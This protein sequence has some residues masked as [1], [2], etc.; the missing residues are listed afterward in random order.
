MEQNINPTTESVPVSEFKGRT[1]QLIGWRLLGTLIS[2]VTLGICMPWAHCMVMRWETNHTYIDGQQLYFDGKG[3]QLFGRYLLWGLLTIVTIGIYGLFVPV[4]FRR[5]RA[6]HTRLATEAEKQPETPAAAPNAAPAPEAPSGSS[7]GGIIAGFIVAGVLV[8][9]LCG[10][11]VL[12]I[13]TANTPTSLN[14]GLL[15]YLFNKPSQHAASNNT[16]DSGFHFG[17]LG[18]DFFS[19]SE[20]GSFEFDIEGLPEDFNGTIQIIQNEDGS[21]TF[22]YG[23]ESFNSGDVIVTPVPSNDL[24][25]QW[26]Q[27]FEEHHDTISFMRVTTYT[28]REDGTYTYFHDTYEFGSGSGWHATGLADFEERGSYTYENGELTL[29][30]IARFVPP[31][32]VGPDEPSGW[33]LTDEVE[34]Y[35]ASVFNDGDRLYMGVEGQAPYEWERTGGSET[36]ALNQIYP[37]GI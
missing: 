12:K 37:N 22:F 25:G 17:D 5:W 3:G 1:I 8:M 26:M 24:V 13:F 28:F 7:K 31:N 27:C 18:D 34:V 32:E 2:V 29:Y 16:P 36:E 21:F 14:Q 23:D 11:L 6:G 30:N 4:K 35:Q 33:V 10:L 19:G 15:Q 9:I 20:D